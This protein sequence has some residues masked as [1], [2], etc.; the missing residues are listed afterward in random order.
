MRLAARL[1]RLETER[2]DTTP[3]FCIGLLASHRGISYTVDD[4]AHGHRVRIERPDG[5]SVAS[6]STFDTVEAA[7]ASAARYIDDHHDELSGGT[8]A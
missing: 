4:A 5:T 7:Q 8:R 6:V 2:R 1:E 3:R